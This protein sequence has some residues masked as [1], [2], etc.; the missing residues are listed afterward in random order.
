MT[1]EL[2]HIVARKPLARTINLRVC[3]YGVEDAG[4]FRS[5]E[6]YVK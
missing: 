4:S 3:H 2:A 1:P 6:A 5:L